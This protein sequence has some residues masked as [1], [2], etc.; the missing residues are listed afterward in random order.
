MYIFGNIL[1]NTTTAQYTEPNV[2]LRH[3]LITPKKMLDY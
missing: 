3:W 2:I 1:K